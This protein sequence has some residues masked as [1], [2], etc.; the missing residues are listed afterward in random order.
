MNNANASGS[1]FVHSQEKNAA[2]NVKL[3]AN[4]LVDS[5]I[6]VP[7]QLDNP[8]DAAITVG[9][10]DNK[11]RYQPTAGKGRNK[12][13]FVN[14]FSIG[15]GSITTNDNPALKA[16]NG[17]AFFGADVFQDPNTGAFFT[18]SKLGA[19]GLSNGGAEGTA[20]GAAFDPIDVAPR[21]YDYQFSVNSRL[22]LGGPLDTGG[23]TFFA[24]DSR[25]SGSRSAV[26]L[27]YER[28]QPFDEALWSLSISAS[29]PVGG[30]EDLLVDFR[31]SEDAQTLGYLTLPLRPDGMPY[32]ED[33]FEE[34][35]VRAFKMEGLVASLVDFPLFPDGTDYFASG[36]GNN[37]VRY[38]F[39]LNAGLSAAA[40][41][42]PTSL[43]LLSTGAVGLL[44]YVMR[45][46]A[47]ANRA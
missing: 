1:V 42:E 24:V 15:A 7:F 19:F 46:R 16:L 10:G 40:V 18:E 26:D 34:Q 35:I 30:L 44:V 5:P 21:T 45:H 9:E 11:R 14:F 17:R 47:S 39:G 4:E 22:E 8:T 43:I 29:G 13:A 31:L 27:F 37:A 41:P 36:T 33:D 2:A 3:S 20:A 12:P 28:G 23:L 38:G 32:T 25:L 6:N